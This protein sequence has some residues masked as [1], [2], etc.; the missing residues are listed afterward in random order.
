MLEY[1]NCKLGTLNDPRYSHGNIYPVVSE[2][3]GG[4]MFAPQNNSDGGHWFYNP[5]TPNLEG[6][7]LTHM[8][9]VWVGD[10]GHI[11]LSPFSGEF[12]DIN[13]MRKSS[14]NKSSFELHPHYISFYLN[15][16]KISC[17]LTPSTHG[18]IL[19]LEN[20]GQNKLGFSLLPFTDCGNFMVKENV[21][22]GYTDS[23]DLV[24]INKN[25]KQYYHIV[26]SSVPCSFKTVE[27]GGIAVYFNE[28]AV[29]IKF[30]TSFIS[31]EQA[32]INYRR[33]VEKHTYDDLLKNNETLWESYLSRINV[34]DTEEK[35][36]LIYSCL[37]RALIFPNK[38]YELDNTNSPIHYNVD[39]D[40]VMPGVFYTNNG[41]WDTYRTV[42]PFLSIFKPEII[43]EIIEGYVNYAKDTGWLP[44]WHAGGELGT[45]PGNLIESVIADAASKKLLKPEV[46]KEAYKYL[47]KN[48]TTCPPNDSLHGRTYLADYIKYGY[49]PN[50]NKESINQTFDYSYGDYCVLQIANMFKDETIISLLNNRQ[51]SYRNLYDSSTGFIRGKDIKGNFREYFN[52][53]EWGGD[54]TE[55]S[56]YQNGLHMYHDYEGFASLIG[57]KEKLVSKVE[58]IFNLPKKFDVGAY[59]FEIHEM[60]EMAYPNDDL[61]Q[62]AIS[63]QPSFH[64]PWIFSLINEREKTEYYVEK[65]L[66]NAFKCSEDGFPGDEDNGTMACWVLFAYMGLY[67][68]C[69]GSLEYSCS[70]PLAN[71]SIRGKNIKRYIQNTISHDEV[72]RGMK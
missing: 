72:I 67:P 15:K 59:G 14:Y 17:S 19:K 10:F 21:L 34:D 20:N 22:T 41:F 61:G 45:M 63:N 18:C 52:P 31:V 46:L 55:G 30:A 62:M 38:M 56:Y 5:T 26:F 51:Y 7:R 35:K 71:I 42:Y 53:F 43:N 3:F 58:E 48:V 64:F 60:S 49:V 36:N 70:K 32:G 12:S 8:P 54:N 6:I 1:V 33:E 65:V 66:N 69:P 23:T 68:V 44:R 57:G 37:Y 40:K 9:S 16:Y 11:L 27:N 29:E 47:V 24:N 2:P 28:N 25:I 50:N 39:I 4:V 13:W